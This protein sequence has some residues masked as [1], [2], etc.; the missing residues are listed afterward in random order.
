MLQQER[1]KVLSTEDFYLQLIKK[2][3]NLTIDDLANMNP[4]QRTVL[5]QGPLIVEYSGPDAHQRFVELQERR[6][7]DKS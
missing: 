4:V 2:Y 1:E 6:Q 5:N 3:P 7:V